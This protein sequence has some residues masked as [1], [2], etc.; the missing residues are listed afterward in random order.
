[1]L[2]IINMIRN[3]N[4][5]RLEIDIFNKHIIS[6]LIDDTKEMR[7]C[8]RVSTPDFFPLDGKMAITDGY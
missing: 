6:V 4:T 2:M 5:A 1:M 7:Q 8:I 3:Y